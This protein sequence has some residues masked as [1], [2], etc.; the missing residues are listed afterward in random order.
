MNSMLLRRI[1]PI[2]SSPLESADT[3]IP[4]PG[5]GEIRLRVRCCAIC[6]TDLHVIEGD[7]RQ[8]QMPIVPGH[9]VVGAVDALGP[10]STRLR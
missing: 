9:Q 2:E 3:P 10:S 7:L 4:E 6:R 5:P 8:A 1:A